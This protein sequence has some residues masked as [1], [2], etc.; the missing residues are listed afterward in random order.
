[1]DWVVKYRG[2]YGKHQVFENGRPVKHMDAPF[3]S[4]KLNEYG[5]HLL[6]HANHTLVKVVRCL[7][8]LSKPYTL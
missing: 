8:G 5:D 4:I 3:E 2:R 1:M 6:A 7:Y